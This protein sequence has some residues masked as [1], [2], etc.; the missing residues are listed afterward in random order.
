MGEISIP[1]SRWE[2]DPQ[3]TVKLLRSFRPESLFAA[4]TIL[5]A[6]ASKILREGIDAKLGLRGITT[7]AERLLPNHRAI[8]ARA[9][10]CPVF[11]RYGLAELTGYVAQECE[12][13]EG[14]HVNGALALAE[15]IKNGEVCG[16]GETGR[17]IL[18]NLHNYAMPFIRY[19]TGDLATVGDECSCG[20]SFQ[21][22]E[23][24]EGRSPSWVLTQTGPVSWAP[25][26][27]VVLSMNIGT[28]EQF[29]FVQTKIGELT[30]L[31]APTSAL[32]SQQIHQLTQRL[33]SRH[34]LV[35]ID[36]EST[37]LIEPTVSGKRSLFKPL[38]PES[39]A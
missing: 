13:H 39:N 37:D 27:A 11:D 19:D 4:V 29:Q 28:I 12:A 14:L 31:V 30:L 8:I 1:A 5:S 26:L 20:R 16:P 36:V 15:V 3:A 17:L 38:H 34:P 10:D 32:N 22:L 6:L 23:R 35:K 25:F 33:N 2:P 7:T 24:I 21:V 9:F 18:T